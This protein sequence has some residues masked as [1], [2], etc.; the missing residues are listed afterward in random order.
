M[1]KDFLSPAVG[2]IRWDVIMSAPVVILGIVLL[3]V[4]LVLRNVSNP[5]IKNDMSGRAVKSMLSWLILALAI[6]LLILPRLPH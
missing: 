4:F 5:P 1:V 6:G 2:E 3:I